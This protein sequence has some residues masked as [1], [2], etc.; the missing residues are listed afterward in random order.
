MIDKKLDGTGKG[1]FVYD[2]NNDILMFKIKER[3]YEKSIEFKKFIADIDSKGFVSGIRIIDA[4]KIF[5]IN[6]YTLSNI[7]SWEFK[8][9]VENGTITIRLSFVGK[10]RNKEVAIENFTQQLTT[11]L[12]GHK[13]KESIVECATV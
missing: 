7:I 11:L 5:G 4:S 13:L 10:V 3:D 6:K 2:I 1:D 9:V 12:N 8:T